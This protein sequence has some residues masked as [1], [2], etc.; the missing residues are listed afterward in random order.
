MIALTEKVY[1]EILELPTNER[2]ELAD[3]L[4]LDLTPISNSVDQA[5]LQE[6]ERRLKEYRDG[7]VK[8]IPREQVFKNIHKRFG[9]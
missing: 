3:K 6:S 4:L 9:A 1:N 2:V 5:W 8:A 7:K